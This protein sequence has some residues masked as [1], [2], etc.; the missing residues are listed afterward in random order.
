MYRV[1]QWCPGNNAWL[2]WGIYADPNE[3]K[4]YMGTKQRAYPDTLWRLVEV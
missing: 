2:V 3:A 1:E 4:D